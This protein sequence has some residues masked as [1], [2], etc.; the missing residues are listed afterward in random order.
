MTVKRAMLREDSLFI[1]IQIR[2]TDLPSDIEDES[3]LLPSWA[4]KWKAI[5]NL[6]M[7]ERSIRI[8]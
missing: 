8:T 2:N 4:S 5:W 1:D 3:E 7:Q 6:C